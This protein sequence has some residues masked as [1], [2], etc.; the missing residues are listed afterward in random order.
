MPTWLNT[1]LDIAN[2][3][4]IYRGDSLSG[5]SGQTYPDVKIDTLPKPASANNFIT[6][7]KLNQVE[8]GSQH[9]WEMQ[10]A[11]APAPFNGWFPAQSVEEVSKGASVSSMSFGIDEVNMLNSYGAITMRCEILD[12]E[13]ETLT[14]WLKSW[15]KSIGTS[16]STGQAYS[17]FRYLTDILTTMKIT[18]YNWQKIRVSRDEYYVIPVGNI[19]LNRN[20]DPALRVLN[21]NFAVFGQK[22]T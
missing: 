7:N 15:Q 12:D 10:I 3:L 13:N 4:N 19:S 2:R 9:L 1:A 22:E 5:I 8:F 17:G 14:K 21:V 6:L 20:N 11:G 16:P 18:K